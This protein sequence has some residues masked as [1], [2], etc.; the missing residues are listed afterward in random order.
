MHPFALP[1]GT[2]TKVYVDENKLR[3]AG[4]RRRCLIACFIRK[5]AAFTAFCLE[6]QVISQ[7]AFSRKFGGSSNHDSTFVV[8]VL[9]S[10]REEMRQIQAPCVQTPGR[11][12]RLRTRQTVMAIMRSS[13]AN[14]A[15]YNSAGRH[16][17][18]ALIG[19]VSLF[20]R[21]AQC[22]AWRHGCGDHFVLHKR[23][24]ILKVTRASEED[25]LP[26]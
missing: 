14:N 8:A 17:N 3:W 18:D 6:V 23:I 13:S 24:H 19:R 5:C 1:S 16:G 20:H 10:L 11:K 12:P 22:S 9:T 7:Y 25:T 15:G 26:S 4:E 2:V 21:F